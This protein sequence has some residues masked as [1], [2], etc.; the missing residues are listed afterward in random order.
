MLLFYLM[1]DIYIA[2]DSFETKTF[3]YSMFHHYQY[4]YT[5]IELLIEK[6]KNLNYCF[7]D[8]TKLPYEFL[9]WPLNHSW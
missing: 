4:L 1:Q 9:S 6:M 5:V 3:A 2:T 8:T 7:S